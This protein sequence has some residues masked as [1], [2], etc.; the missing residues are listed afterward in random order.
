[1]NPQ[2]SPQLLTGRAYFQKTAT[3]E[4]LEDSEN[5]PD[6]AVI[7]ADIAENL[8]TALEQ[9]NTIQEDIASTGVARIRV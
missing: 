4:S 1:M 7:A 5:L 2:P 9:F 6:P 3:R 8:E